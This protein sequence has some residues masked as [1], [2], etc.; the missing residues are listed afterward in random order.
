MCKRIIDDIFRTD[1]NKDID[2]AVDKILELDA[3]I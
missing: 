3:F 1:I 2:D